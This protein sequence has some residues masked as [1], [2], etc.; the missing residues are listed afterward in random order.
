MP[1]AYVAHGRSAR[2]GGA[3]SKPRRARAARSAGTAGRVRWD[4]VGRLALMLVL[5]A[6]VYLYVSAGVH[7]FSTWRQAHSDSATVGALAREHLQL[8]RQ[9][10]AL[11]RQ[12]TVEEE[13]RQLGMIRK[14]EQPYIISGLPNN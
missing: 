2:S 14:G 8:E 3:R 4:R 6:L 7:M 10:E 1:A 11:S 5:V 13:A 12:G 9:H